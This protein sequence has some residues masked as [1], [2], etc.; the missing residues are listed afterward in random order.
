MSDLKDLKLPQ[1]P[2]LEETVEEFHVDVNGF[3]D[4]VPMN[5]T[6]IPDEESDLIVATNHISGESF[7][8]TVAEFSKRLRA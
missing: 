3:E 5:W 2:P 8:G 1:E 6:I 7:E 4:R